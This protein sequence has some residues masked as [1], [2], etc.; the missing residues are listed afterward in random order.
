M[1]ETTDESRNWPR[2]FLP[3]LSSFLISVAYGLISRLVFADAPPSTVGTLSVSFFLLVPLVLGVLTVLLGPDEQRSKAG[4]VIVAPWVP[5]IVCMIVAGAFT[6]ELLFCIILASPLILLLSSIGGGIGWVIWKVAGRVMSLHANISI[7]LLL[8]LLPHLSGALE[9]T[10]PVPSLKRQVHSQIEIA[11]PPEV[12]WTQI[13]TLD[14]IREDE[15]SRPLFYWV[16]LP[17]PIEA[18]MAC[19]EVGCI[20]N[21]YWEYGLSFNGTITQIETNQSYWV[22]LQADTSDVHARMAPLDEIGGA[23]DMVDDGYRIE[24]LENGQSRLHLYSTYLLTTRINF[25]A[26]PWIDFLLKDIQRYIL[27]IEK[28]RSEAM[29]R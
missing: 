21:G 2:L 29:T 20:R 28:I 15:T 5:A 17:R 6:W 19:Q 26:A 10:F 13:T 8:M 25:Y 7:T 24:S 23:F 22:D 16:G 27:H 4:W 3:A 1:E 12:V 9:S 18:R 11:A 14:P